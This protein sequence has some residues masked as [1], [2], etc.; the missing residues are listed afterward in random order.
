MQVK[1]G[2]LPKEQIEE[3]DIAIGQGGRG[4]IKVV[5][6]VRPACMRRAC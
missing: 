4:P 5:Q 6:R 2:S 1:S 3:V